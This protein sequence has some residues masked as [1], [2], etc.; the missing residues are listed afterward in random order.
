MGIYI[1]M[2]QSGG[3]TMTWN[4]PKGIG[5]IKIYAFLCFFFFTVK[6]TAQLYEKGNV[7]GD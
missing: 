6:L 2:T 1:E 3:V 4:T 5:N 7:Y